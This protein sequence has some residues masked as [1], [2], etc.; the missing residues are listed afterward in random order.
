MDQE[1]LL[2]QQERDL[3]AYAIHRN[4]ITQHDQGDMVTGNI[5]PFYLDGGEDDYRVIIN[6]REESIGVGRVLATIV[7]IVIIEL[8]PGFFNDKKNE[9]TRL[10]GTEA[11]S[12]LPSDFAAAKTRKYYHAGREPYADWIV[13]LPS[14]AILQSEIDFSF[15]PHS[16]PTH[17]YVAPPS[18]PVTRNKSETIDYGYFNDKAIDVKH[19]ILSLARRIM[20]QLADQRERQRGSHNISHNISHHRSR[21]RSPSRGGARKRITRVS[22]KQRKQRK[23]CKSRKQRK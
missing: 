3:I 5:G 13:A 15:F 4:L 7:N 16:N 21:S 9:L 1:Q 11:A 2:K 23:Q 6:Q 10:I 14:D 20:T 22:R 19:E 18:T 17:F 8:V 12:H